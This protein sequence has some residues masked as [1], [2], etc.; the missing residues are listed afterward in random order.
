MAV[1]NVKL[2]ALLETGTC[3]SGNTAFEIA[4]PC[5]EGTESDVLLLVASIFAGLLGLG[6]FA[7]RGKPPWSER[8]GAMGATGLWAWAIFF[9]ATGAVSLYHS[10]N[11]DSIPAD[12]KLGGEIVGATFLFMGLPALAFALW[13]TLD[14]IRSRRED[15]GPG[16][17]PSGPLSSL[18]THASSVAGPTSGWIGS[19]KPAPPGAAATAAP[20]PAGDAGQ[21]DSIERLERLQR[22]RESGALTEGEFQL[23]KNRILNE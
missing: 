15:P 11:P 16:H 13:V 12:G 14:G 17:S 7:A 6:L 3:A 22:L 20:E 4:R 10:L 2:I 21:G 23:Q 8:R 9:T 19:I 5:P 18:P 1:F